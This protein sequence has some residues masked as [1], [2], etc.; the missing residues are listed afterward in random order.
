MV[1][2]MWRELENGVLVLGK[3]LVNGLHGDCKRLGFGL[4][5]ALSLSILL[6]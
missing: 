2:I 4:F 5:L 1:I 3:G 6:A